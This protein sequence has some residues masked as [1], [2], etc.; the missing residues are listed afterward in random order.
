MRWVACNARSGTSPVGG[1][2]PIDGS[3][4]VRRFGRHE[5]AEAGAARG[6]PGSPGLSDGHGTTR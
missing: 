5:A 3:V 2:A 1:G 4:C 6:V